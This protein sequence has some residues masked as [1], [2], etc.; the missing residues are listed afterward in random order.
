[1][2][3][4]NLAL[5][6]EIARRLGPLLPDLTFVGGCATGLLITDPASAP[7]RSTRDVDV[8]AE[9]TS[10][11]EYSALAERLR[12]LG[13]AED[14]SE[15]APLCRWQFDEMK[16]DVMPTN[17]VILG[18]SNRWYEGAIQN[19]SDLELERGL[20]IRLVRGPYFLGM[21]LEAFRSRGRDD[22]WA[23]SDLEDII[24]I[25]D[26]RAELV[27]EVAIT[28]TKSASTSRPSSTRFVDHR[29]FGMLCPD[30][31][32]P[33]WRANRERT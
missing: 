11:A 8:I 16:L 20:L 17:P 33:I 15:D 25:V 29:I 21:K 12:A 28:S 26:G 6:R 23:S 18:F 24:T 14:S 31:C 13:F 32:F 9:L 10:Y 4:P 30:S 22:Y 7:V 5:T 3:N 19:A 1:M 2:Q 27:D